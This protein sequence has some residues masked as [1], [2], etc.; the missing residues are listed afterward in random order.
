MFALGGRASPPFCWAGENCSGFVFDVRDE[1]LWDS[2]LRSAAAGGSESGFFRTAC[3]SQAPGTRSFL[4]EESGVKE[5]EI[6]MEEG[7]GNC[8][9][10]AAAKVTLDHCN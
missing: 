5:G 6:E 3:Q 8:G 10:V 1:E 9:S 7:G 2:Y 4:Q